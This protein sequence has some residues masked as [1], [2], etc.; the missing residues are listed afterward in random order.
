M[1]V[2]H[3]TPCSIIV[4]KVKGN[5]TAEGYYKG[6]MCTVK[7][8]SSPLE[9]AQLLAKHWGASVE[10]HTKVS[11]SVTWFTVKFGE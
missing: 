4:R 1:P 8:N 2:P 3:G 11:C 10:L 5:Y 7:H 6:I 9:A